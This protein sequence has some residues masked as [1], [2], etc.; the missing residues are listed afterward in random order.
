VYHTLLFIGPAIQSEN[1][2]GKVDEIP[3][4]GRFFTHF[5]VTYDSDRYNEKDIKILHILDN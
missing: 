1:Y 3:L 2:N 4:K 5:S